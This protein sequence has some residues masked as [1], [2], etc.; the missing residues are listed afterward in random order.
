[1]ELAESVIQREVRIPQNQRSRRR[2]ARD[3]FEI[4]AAVRD[5]S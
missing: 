5:A 2:Q 1:M 4:E 3:Q